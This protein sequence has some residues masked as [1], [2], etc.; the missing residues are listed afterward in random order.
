MHSIVD[1]DNYA[2][3]LRLH[4]GEKYGESAVLASLLSG[5]FVRKKL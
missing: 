2:V 5:R 1:A 4:S 3:I